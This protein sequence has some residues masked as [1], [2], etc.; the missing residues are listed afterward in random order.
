[1]IG[2]IVPLVLGIAFL[3]GSGDV[4]W[5][6]AVGGPAALVGIWCADDAYVRAGQSVP[7]S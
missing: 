5:L 4:W 6:A 2:V 3:A 1:M 7:L